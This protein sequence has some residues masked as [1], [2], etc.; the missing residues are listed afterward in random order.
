MSKTLVVMLLL[1][2]TASACVTT[3]DGD[4][5][6]A[7]IS[8]LQAEQAAM[9]KALTQREAKLAE[10][11]AQARTEIAQLEKLITRAE[12]TLKNND[13]AAA[14][15][16]EQAREE[17]RTLRGESEGLAFKLEKMELDLK[18]FKE[19]VDIRLSS[20][21][22]TQENYPE[23]A[24]ELL[25]LGQKAL[26]D[27]PAAAI[28][29]MEAF[30]KRHPEDARVDEAMFAI[31]EAYRG[32]GQHVN[33]IF[34]FQRILKEQRRSSFLPKATYRIGQGFDAL[35]KCT[36]AQLFYG[37]VVKKYPTASFAKDASKRSKELEQTCK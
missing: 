17:V 28:K 2:F 10:T 31:G 25:A 27:D 30:I 23:N 33:S 13:L 1:L 14:G 36:Q 15:D 37:A 22:P 34:A 3:S 29:A 32:Q 26:K 8:A 11:I 5:M 21:A 24:T 12:G 6:R 19:D 20:A 7:D 35:N 4:K 18:S 9:N 16:L